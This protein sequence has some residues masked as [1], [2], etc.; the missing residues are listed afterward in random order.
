MESAFL[1]GKQAYGWGMTMSACPYTGELRKRWADGWKA[2][3]QETTAGLAGEALYSLY[4]ESTG[5]THLPWEDLSPEG[6]DAWADRALKALTPAIPKAL[7]G[8]VAKS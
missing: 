6:R 4:V 3:Q 7:E 5:S 8:E 2:A 1:D